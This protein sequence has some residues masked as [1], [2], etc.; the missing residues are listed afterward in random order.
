MKKFSILLLVLVIFYGSSCSEEKDEPKARTGYIAEGEW[1]IPF[2][3]ILD[4]G[5]G[6]DGI[7][8]LDEPNFITPSEA[9][10]LED[11]EL[12]IGYSD[13][14]ETKAYSHLVMNW[15]EIANDWYNK[16]PI[17]VIYCPLTGT[18]TGWHRKF[19]DLITTFGVS[20]L[21]YNA[22]V[23]PYDRNSESN[24]SQLTLECVNGELIGTKPTMVQL[25]ETSWS[26]WQTFFPNT[27]VL[28]TET[29]HARNY[30]AYPYGDYR[31]VDGL[32]FQVKDPDDR[33]HTK[34]RVHTVIRED[35]AKAYR[36]G[37]FPKD[38][39]GIISDEVEGQNTVII[40]SQIQNFIISF[41]NIKINDEWLTFSLPEGELYKE[42]KLTSAVLMT[43]QFGNEWNVLGMAVSGP[44]SGTELTPTNGII[45]YWFPWSSFYTTVDIYEP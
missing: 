24:W 6:K 3:R 34:E 12:V 5:P 45:G 30:A 42:G 7:P 17:A 41:Y 22:N 25:I 8:A 19:G 18:A 4:G 21:L 1:S 14:Q 13:G 40:G 35:Y 26:T 31:S 37:S 39:V 33:L 36:F 16:E 28:S 2:T 15:H 9:T 11:H 10:Y 23:I 38:E 29:G 43:D 20:G 44:D 27:V 32:I